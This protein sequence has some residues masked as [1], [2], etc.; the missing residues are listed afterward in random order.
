MFVSNVHGY[1]KI[2]SLLNNNKMK[3]FYI[4][5]LIA[6]LAVSLPVLP[7]CKK[8]FLDEVPDNLLTLDEVFKRRTETEK[9]L[10]NVYSYIRDEANQWNDGGNPWL[11]LSDEVDVT[12]NRSNYPTFAMNLG[13]W[14]AS[15]NYYNFWTHYYRGIRSATTFIQRIEECTELYSYYTNGDSVVKQYRAEARF[16]RAFFYFN[17][18]RQ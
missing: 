3:K 7:A 13:A 18:I 17:L 4:Q 6:A 11:G 1:I 15:S 14:N 5:L 9:Y 8:N 10:A 2:G 12:W 16:L